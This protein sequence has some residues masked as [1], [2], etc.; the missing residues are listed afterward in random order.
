MNECKKCTKHDLCGKREVF[1]AVGCVDDFQ[2]KPMTN[3]DKIR[4]LNDEELAKFLSETTNCEFCKVQ[5]DDRHSLPTVDSCKYR[6]KEWLQS[7][8]F[9]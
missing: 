2:P 1:G 6:F 8:V 9:E 5:C 3:A 7:E 4:S